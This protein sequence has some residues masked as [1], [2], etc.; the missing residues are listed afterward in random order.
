V[1]DDEGLRNMVFTFA[2]W[3]LLISMACCMLVVLH[4]RLRSKRLAVQRRSAP[5]VLVGEIATVP[6][7]RGLFGEGGGARYHAECPICLEMFGPGGEIKVLRCGHA[8][9]KDCL[10][11]WLQRSR[12]CALCREEV[13]PAPAKE[14][15][16]AVVPAGGAAAVGRANT[17]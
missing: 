4:A 15:S 6:Y 12:T 14:A 11:G 2:L 7:E 8:F 17:V 10:E 3:G 13:A 16:A 5:A 1:C 9:H